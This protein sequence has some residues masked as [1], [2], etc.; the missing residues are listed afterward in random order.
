M[1]S[2]LFITTSSLATNP[3]LVKEFEFLKIHYKCTVLCFEHEGWSL[4]PSREIIKKNTEVNF[5]VI[6]RRDEYI[7]TLFSKLLHK[8]AIYLNPFFKSNLKIAAFASN[9]KTPQLLFE[10]HQLLARNKFDRIIAHNLGAFYPSY[11]ISEK[12]RS[13]LQLDIEDFHLGEKTYFN[14]KH[15]IKNRF[16]IMQKAFD[17][18]QTITYASVGIKE[19]CQD[20]FRINSKINSAVI[21]NSFWAKEFVKPSKSSNALKLVWFSQNISANRGLEAVFRTAKKYDHVEFHLIGKRNE[22]FLNSLSLSKNIIFH[23]PMPQEQLHNFLSTM[24]IGLALENEKADGNRDI[25]LTNKFLAY[26]QSGLYILATP[27]F[28]QIH[29]L[30]KIGSDFGVVIE[31]SLVDEIKKLYTDQISLI[32]KIKRWNSAKD[33]SWDK[34]GEKLIKIMKKE[35]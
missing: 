19:K 20:I 9:D 12:Y 28:G 10:A 34:E 25:C 30:N 1:K 26:T 27:T 31:N 35:N 11:R 18:A 23:N 17:K 13:K 8:M 5:V 29:F 4:K 32:A 33:F 16:L 15:E 21:I 6:K 3:R 24:D 14:H 22:D 2:I 7:K